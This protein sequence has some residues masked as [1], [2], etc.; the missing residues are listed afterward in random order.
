MLGLKVLKVVLTLSVLK[1]MFFGLELQA[2]VKYEKRTFKRTVDEIGYKWNFERNYLENSLKPMPFAIKPGNY[3]EMEMYKDELWFKDWN[4]MNFLIYDVGNGKE[5]SVGERGAGPNGENGQIMFYDVSDFGVHL[6]DFSK[7]SFKA[8]SGNE[9]NFESYFQNTNVAFYRGAY[10]SEDKYFVRYDDDLKD[11]GFSFIIYD[12]KTAKNLK[13][14]SIPSLIDVK[15]FDNMYMAYAGRFVKSYDKNTIIYY[16]RYGGLFFNFSSKGE[17]RYAKKT[18]DKTPIPKVKKIEFGEG[19]ATRPEVEFEFFIDASANSS[20]FMLL[21]VLEGKNSNVID[22]Y[23]ISSGDYKYSI[24]LP[25]LDDGQEAKL[26]ACNEEYVYVMF[27]ENDVRR[28]VLA[29]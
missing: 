16:C 22:M 8:Y 21:N 29:K 11:L 6:Y 24:S 15:P 25:N 10:M 18:I 4:N 1:M 27:E 7:R 9:F 3:L 14:H 5:R 12:A 20:L 19:F 2:Q 23:D 28:Y 13:V 17:F 26:I